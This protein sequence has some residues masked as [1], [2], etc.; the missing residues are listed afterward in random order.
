MDATLELA[1]LR[2]DFSA[3]AR[4][5]RLALIERL[6]NDPP[7]QPRT[8]AALHD[9]LL[10]CLAYPPDAATAA[11]AHR[12]L[13][14]LIEPHAPK[15]A[16][17]KPPRRS[18]SPA[19]NSGIAGSDVRTTFSLPLLRW[20]IEAEPH[21][22]EID[23]DADTSGIEP[24]LALLAAPAELDGVL[25]PLLSTAEWLARA[26]DASTRFVS[27]LA[28]LLTA[29]SDLQEDG[30]A[31]DHLWETA[32][33]P[34]RWRLADR[35]R[36]HTRF[37]PR[38]IFHQ[39][40]PLLRHVDLATALAR[41]LPTPERLSR[42]ARIEL[43]ST[44]RAVL[45]ARGRETDPVTHADPR[46]VTLLRLE[47]G[48]DVA[49]FG[50]TPARR[51]PIESYVGFVAARNR[52]PIAYGGGWVFFGRCEIGVNLFEEFRGGESAFI[53]AQVLRVYARTF[54]VRQFLVP[55]YQFG[56]DN[57]EAL[58]SGAF[59]FYYRLGFRPV[60]PPVR[61]L[62]DAEAGRI[63]ADPRART[64]IRTLRRFAG[65]KLFL[66]LPIAPAGPAEVWSPAAPD[67]ERVGLAVTD[68]IARAAD[69]AQRRSARLRAAERRARLAL[70]VGDR[71]PWPAERRAGALRL[72]PLV[73]MIGDLRD[74]SSADR[75]AL[76]NVLWTRGGPRELD[77]V[78]ACRRARRWQAA[79]AL[80]AA[81]LHEAP[82]LAR[83]AP[84]E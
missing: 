66:D 17:S 65:G 12:A 27:D 40:A 33:V 31:L 76:W 56:A 20:L 35:S 67:L 25:C 36:T 43:I 21:A 45:A 51:L 9:E 75:H 61:R 57:P 10:Y 82:A 69:R 77:Y 39:R 32:N 37:P 29:L 6:A 71:R 80:A 11:A 64:P 47:R 48:V 5:T 72:A 58:R 24:L 68:W 59:W 34:I 8:R 54:A 63:A 49:L 41:R 83:A 16:A 52:V 15:T 3:P 38:P 4:R 50:M 42:A 62:A 13:E 73:A 14:R 84:T 30:P 7:P 70:S 18:T 22:V 1:R 28:W 2:R 44:A 78:R 60:A 26:R 74:W 23:H 55:P 79:L 53:F 19:A 46:D 81:Q